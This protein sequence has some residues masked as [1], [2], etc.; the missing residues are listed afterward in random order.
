MYIYSIYENI[1]MYACVCINT[2]S[3]DALRAGL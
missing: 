3:D 1:C 2:L